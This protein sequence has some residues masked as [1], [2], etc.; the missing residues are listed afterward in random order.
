MENGRRGRGERRQDIGRE[1]VVQKKGEY[2]AFDEEG[3]TYCRVTRE[4]AQGK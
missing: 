1:K 2:E 4:E 3:S